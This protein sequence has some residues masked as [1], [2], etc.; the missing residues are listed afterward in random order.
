MSHYEQ[1]FTNYINLAIQGIGNG[2]SHFSK[3]VYWGIKKLNKKKSNFVILGVLVVIGWALI[4]FR[5]TFWGMLPQKDYLKYVKYL[6]YLSPGIP[7]LFLY[8]K[9]EQYNKFIENFTEKFDDM[10]FYRGTRKVHDSFTGQKIE[11]KNFPVFLDQEEKGKKVIYTFKTNIPLQTWKDKFEDIQTAF[12]CNIIK[13]VNDKKSKQIVKLHTVPSEYGLEDYIPWTDDNIREADFEITVGCAML[14][15]VIFDLNK[16][17]HALIAGV[18]GSGKSV[19]TRCIFWQCVKKGVLPYMIDFK[20]G[21]EFG[22]DYEKFGEVIMDRKRALEVLRE[23][24]KENEERLKLFRQQGVKN[25]GE[26]NKKFPRKKLCRI[27]LFCDEVAEMLDKK[28]KVKQEKKI[29]EEIEAELS[30]LAR[31][32]RAT[33]INMIL[34]TQRP[35]ANVIPGQIKNN[36]PIRISGRMVDS[37]ASE[38]V[39][40]NTQ[41]TKIDDTLGRFMYTIGSDTFEFQAYCYEDKHLKFG[42]YVKGGMLTKKGT[43]GEDAEEEQEPEAGKE[44]PKQKKGILNFFKGW[45]KKERQQPEQKELLEQMQPEQE[46]KPERKI[47]IVEDE[48]EEQE[49]EEQEPEKGKVI[50]RSWIFKQSGNR[51]I[52]EP[53][54]EPQQETEEVPENIRHFKSGEKLQTKEPIK[55]PQG[56]KLKKEPEQLQPEPEPEPKQEQPEQQPEPDNKIELQKKQKNKPESSKKGTKVVVNGVEYEGF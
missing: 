48:P 11:K 31:L 51:K 32:S 2:I 7:L 21:V 37:Q 33:G 53:E 13:M 38:M 4:R 10:N 43:P 46:Q 56:L 6:F 54:E 3:S 18:T 52:E 55:Q 39:L 25:L 34:A 1:E 9:G 24:T 22:L 23:L 30:T 42:N 47:Y 19:L 40:G 12:D 50:D 41:A 26:Y 28:G 44:Q 29:Y 14:E 17:P 8:G 35:D 45:K 49:Q 15:E 5:V 27:L 36:L 16:V 20:G